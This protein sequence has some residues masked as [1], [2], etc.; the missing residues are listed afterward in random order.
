[1]TLIELINK[2][3][4]FVNS[5]HNSSYANNRVVLVLEGLQPGCRCGSCLGTVYAD[6]GEIKLGNE[7]PSDCYRNTNNLLKNCVEIWL[8]G[9]D[10]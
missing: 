3:Q 8:E 4:E 7:E 10:R 9:L 5:G 1:M 2:L 6:V